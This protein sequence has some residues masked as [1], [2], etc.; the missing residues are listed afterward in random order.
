MTSPSDRLLTVAEFAST[1]GVSSYTVRK[2]IRQKEVSAMNMNLGG[3]LPVY[4]I[5]ENEIDRIKGRIEVNH[6]DPE[7]GRETGHEVP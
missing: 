6:P 7:A 5:K 4:R 3:K 2:W 1:L